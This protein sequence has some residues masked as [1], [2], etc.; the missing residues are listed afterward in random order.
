MREDSKSNLNFSDSG[1][2]DQG[3]PIEIRITKQLHQRLTVAQ[4]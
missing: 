4:L 1:E 3:E 2:E